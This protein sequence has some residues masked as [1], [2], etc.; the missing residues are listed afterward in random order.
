MR[1]VRFTGEP[2]SWAEPGEPNPIWP[3]GDSADHIRGS[4]WA[5]TAVGPLSGWDAGFIAMLNLVLASRFPMFLTWGPDHQLFYNDA[6]APVV[7]GKGQCL[8]LPFST[9]FP[10]AWE[11]VSPTFERALAG[12]ACFESDWEIP[13][14]RNGRLASTWWSFSYSPAADSAGR[15]C[16]VLGVVFETTDRVLLEGQLL[17]S[18]ETLKS[19]TD[20][21]P[22]LLWKCEADGR[23]SWLNKP[24]R[25]YIS[26]DGLPHGFFHD[27]FHDDDGP[28]ILEAYRR[29]VDESDEFY[30]QFRIRSGSGGWRWFLIR[31]RRTFDAQGEP[32]GWFGSGA[33]INDWRTGA[34]LAGHSEQLIAEV[35]RAESTTMWTLD[36][37]TGE[38]RGLNPNFAST[39]ALP[40]GGDRTQWADW[41]E[42]L[43]VEDRDRVVAAT[44]RVAA[45]ET[46]EGLFR[47]KMDSGFRFFRA[48]A[49]PIGDDTTSPRR[50]GGYMVDV[51]R[52]DDQRV[53]IVDADPVGQTRLHHALVKAGF[54]VRAFDDVTALADISNALQPGV[55]VIAS[56]DDPMAIDRAA[57]A[58]SLNGGATWF[59]L[60]RFDDE[61]SAVVHLM[62][63]GAAG[64]FRYG[65][66]PSALVDAVKAVTPRRLVRSAGGAP[67]AFAGLSRRERDV[68]DGLLAGGTNKT[69]AK[70]LGLSPR[71]IETYRAH[72]M[73][74]LGVKSL[75][76]LLTAAAAAGYRPAPG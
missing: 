29:A 19:V 28:A 50:I 27:H 25:D 53:Y 57:G 6:Y 11:R 39:W 71:T 3:K 63:L 55:F 31:S 61:I 1:N 38:M 70:S 4:S 36:L 69:I 21:A 54:R 59:A 42:T 9:V 49:F 15:I 68:L 17:R 18:E 32:L 34:G 46:V 20:L 16:G 56:G 65:D 76:E 60:G 26:M 30:G 2:R 75:A 47:L 7:E 58:L 33:D 66:S 45:G 37:A 52:N 23:L 51:T 74:S 64:V 73:D 40:K 8:G 44:Q 72:L 13:I 43:H 62:K 35:C 67:S 10:E 22:A 41:V 48:I 12:M 14:L 24:F 5:D